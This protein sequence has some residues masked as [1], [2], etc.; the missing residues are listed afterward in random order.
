MLIREISE[1]TQDF[2]WHGAEVWVSM[3]SQINE[4]NSSSATGNWLLT[5]TDLQAHR[6]PHPSSFK[7]RI[8]LTPSGFNIDFA[9]RPSE[10]HCCPLVARM[11]WVFFIEKDT[12]EDSIN[13][14]RIHLDYSYLGLTWITFFGVIKTGEICFSKDMSMVPVLPLT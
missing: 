8:I 10:H 12:S 13:L 9:I 2:C 3:R 6:F 7:Q 11:Q 14:A 1:Y 4:H 5:N